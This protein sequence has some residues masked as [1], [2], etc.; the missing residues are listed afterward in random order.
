MNNLSISLNE[1]M[2]RG[3]KETNKLIAELSASIQGLSKAR[4]LQIDAIQKAYDKRIDDVCSIVS[5]NKLQAERE[6]DKARSTLGDKIVGVEHTLG[7]KFDEN[8]NYFSRW[9]IGIM[10]TLVTLIIAAV[11]SRWFDPTPIVHTMVMFK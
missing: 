4:D 5:D 1:K 3:N 8:R 9:F 11:F 2:E 10:A 6:L 7:E